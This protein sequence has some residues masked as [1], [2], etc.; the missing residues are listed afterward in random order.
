M[1]RSGA[2]QTP[3]VV[4]YEAEVCHLCERA[5]AQLAELRH[6]LGFEL[7]EIAID[8]DP[9]LESR[10]RELIPVVEIDGERVCTYYVQPEPFRRKLAAAQASAETTGL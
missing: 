4:L 5:K 3:R 7:V 2:T 8:G 10:Y 1:G 9:E 6:E